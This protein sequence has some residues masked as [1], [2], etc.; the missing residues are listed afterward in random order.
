V[1]DLNFFDRF[2][3]QKLVQ[4]DVDEVRRDEVRATTTD[5]MDSCRGACSRPRFGAL[6][7]AIPD[8]AGYGRDALCLVLAWRTP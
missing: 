4:D 2:H 6:P 5:E 8:R 3:V 7:L 1:L